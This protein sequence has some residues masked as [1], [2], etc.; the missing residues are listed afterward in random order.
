M[1]K[2]AVKTSIYKSLGAQH[3]THPHLGLCH[4][5]YFFGGDRKFIWMGPNITEPNIILT[6]K[7]QEFDMFAK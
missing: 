1:V 3:P 4:K 2:Y 5:N 7:S 6:K